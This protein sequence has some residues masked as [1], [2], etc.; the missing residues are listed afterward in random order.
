[1][2]TTSQGAHGMVVR[3]IAVLAVVWVTA[4]GGKTPGGSPDAGSIE[5]G[6][7]GAGGGGLEDVPTACTAGTATFHLSA[8]DGRNTSYCVG[9]GCTAEWVTVRT[10]GGVA[11]PIA[12]GCSTSCEDCIPVGCPAICITPKR[13]KSDGER[14]TWDGTYFPD[15]TCGAKQPCRSKRCATPGKYVARMCAALSSS[16]PNALCDVNATPKCAEVE[17]EYPSAATVEGAI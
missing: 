17:F 8:A 15:A 12:F 13:M 6:A 16:D 3:S 9:I 7:G 11:M 4:C 2:T 1:M 5:D 10:P 14:L